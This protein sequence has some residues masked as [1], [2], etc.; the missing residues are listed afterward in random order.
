MTHSLHRCGTVESLKEDY[1]LITMINKVNAAF[2]RPALSKV[3]EIM[4]EAGLCNIGSTFLSTNLPIGFDKAEF[5]KGISGA[6]TLL[7]SFPSR[8]SLKKALIALKEADLG[9]SVT[10]SGLID[11]VKALA[12]ELELKPHTVN[13]SLGVIGKT[14]KLA[15][16]EIM[17]VTTMCGHA[18]IAANLVKKGIQ[19]VKSGDKTPEEASWMAAKPCICGIFNVDRAAQLIKQQAAKG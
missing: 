13:L 17:D 19:D 18:L 9:I 5:I 10:V 14:E 8:D 4:F 11:E 7:C 6:N 3:A 2:T 12:E 16:P 1:V 15:E